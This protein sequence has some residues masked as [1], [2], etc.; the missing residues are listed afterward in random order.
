MATAAPVLLAERQDACLFSLRIMHPPS[1]QS[2]PAATVTLPFQFNPDDLSYITNPYPTYRYLREHAPAYYWPTGRAWVFSRYDDVVAILRDA[3]FSMDFQDWEHAPRRPAEESSEFGRL[4]AKALFTLPPAEHSRVRRLVGRVFAPRALEWMR[5]VAQT[6]VDD[7][8]RGVD[9]STTFDLARDFA[10]AIPL[11]AIGAMLGMTGELEEP[12]RLFGESVS[13]AARPGID[14]EEHDRVLAPFDEGLRRLRAVIEERSRQP[15]TDVL[16]ALVEMR[17]RD[18][19]LTSDEIIELVMALITAGTETVAHLICF[20]V[21]TL[22]RHPEQLALLRRE[23]GLM[24]NALEEVLRYDSFPKN[25]VA[26]FALQDVDIRGVTITQG[27]MVFPLLPAALHDP[28]I[29]PDPETFDIRRDQTANVTFGT[30]L[31][32]CIGA[33]LAR[34]EGESAVGTLLQRFPAMSLAG[35]PR[36]APHPLLRKMAS[37]PVRLR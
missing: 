34:L 19:R 13:R 10:E 23:P 14:P 11:R 37:L 8:L 15:G 17:D 9:E 3:R 21:L 30:G 16:S 33:A 36:F 6:I 5:S 31:H 26:R 24:R 35:P 1:A 29:F 12:F 27:Q 2:G 28:E 18:D 4:I 20:A 22:L 7:T 32:H 25:G